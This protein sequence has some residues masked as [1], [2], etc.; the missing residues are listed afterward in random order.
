MTEISKIMIQ[1]KQQIFFEDVH[2]ALFMIM[3]LYS[4]REGNFIELQCKL[5]DPC[6]IIKAS[7]NVTVT[8]GVVSVPFT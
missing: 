8:E 6:F 4:P 5:L 3:I 1:V 7:N 2:W